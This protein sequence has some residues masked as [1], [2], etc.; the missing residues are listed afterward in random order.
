VAVLFRRQSRGDRRRLQQRRRVAADRQAAEDGDTEYERRYESAR[1]EMRVNHGLPPVAQLEVSAARMPRPGCRRC[2]RAA[3]LREPARAATAPERAVLTD[4]ECVELLRWALPRLRLRWS[5][6][7]RVRRQ[8][9]RRIARRM[10]ELGLADAAAY[11]SRLEADP[12]EWARLDAFCRISISR[13]F[14]DAS[15]FAA[16]EARV[17][18]RLAERARAEGREALRVWSAGCA[19]GEEAWSLA[20]LWKSALAPRI[21]ELRLTIVATD[22]D[23]GLIERARRGRFRA[24]S[25][26][27]VPAEARAA[28]FERHGEDW[29]AREELRGA[30]EFHRQDLRE[31]MPAG[32]FD[33]I[34]CR[35]LAF[36]YFD[37]ELQRSVLARMLEH[38]RPGG[39]LVIGLHEALPE[40]VATLGPW[41]GARAV[42]LRSYPDAE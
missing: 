28:G 2:G 26:R 25:L 13:C 38:L 36:T 17:L 16:L 11:R 6:F 35:N 39:A 30:I 27:E 24:S 19:S 31:E 23:A 20:A 14:R 22:V 21:P 34:L 41:P 29:L 32:G 42:F 18:P 33:L 3:D 4:A 40:P 7:R 9:C 1:G 5:G 37:V 12:A 15:V 10:R 8:V